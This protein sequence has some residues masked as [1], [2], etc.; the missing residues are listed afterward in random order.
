[1]NLQLLLSMS[2]VA[3]SYLPF[4]NKTDADHGDQ[5][6]VA[7]ANIKSWSSEDATTPVSMNH[8]ER[9]EE[10]STTITMRVTHKRTTTTLESAV[11]TSGTYL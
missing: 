11:I 5:T 7:L 8:I 9:S 3:A 2:L 4:T 6:S 1:M 10:L